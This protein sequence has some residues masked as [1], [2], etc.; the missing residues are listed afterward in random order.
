M[1]RRFTLSEAERLLPEIEKSIRAAVSLK[2]DHERAEEALTGI[3]RRVMTTGGMVVDRTQ[4]L[5]LRERR[6][7]CARELQAV[8]ESIQEHG[9]QVKDLDL[10]LVDFPTWFGG[11]EVLLCWKLGEPAIRYWHGTEEGF[12]GRKPIDLEFLDHHRGDAAN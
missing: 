6:E 8:I 3:T 4:V 11:R 7:R 9:A 1:P 10:G 2:A 12:A 5:E